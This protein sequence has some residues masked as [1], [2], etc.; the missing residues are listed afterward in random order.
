[1]IN[2]LLT[3]FIL[4][5]FEVPE[6]SKFKSFVR[7]GLT[8]AFAFCASMALCYAENLIDNVTNTPVGTYDKSEQTVTINENLCSNGL[9][10]DRDADFSIQRALHSYELQALF[11]NDGEETTNTH[12]IVTKSA[13]AGKEAEIDLTNFNDNYHFVPRKITFGD[14]IYTFNYKYEDLGNNVKAPVGTLTISTTSKTPQN[15]YTPIIMAFGS[16]AS[17]YV[18]R[19][20]AICS[21]IEKVIITGNFSEIPSGCFR[22]MPELKSVDA[23]KSQVKRVCSN[24]FGGTYRNHNA[25]NVQTVSLPTDCEIQSGSGIPEADTDDNSGLS[26]GDY[27]SLLK[28]CCTLL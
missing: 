4:E 6:I 28:D 12:A 9:P 25:L 14:V 20:D 24:A 2:F 8:C 23:S 10:K 18:V 7:F 1:M 27:F 22:N 17:E 5:V 26:C 16:T 21:G 13:Q 15:I 3:I 19:E 11:Y